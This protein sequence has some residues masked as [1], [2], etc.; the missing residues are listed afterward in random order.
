MKPT[1][2]DRKNRAYGVRPKCQLCGAR[3]FDW[4]SCPYDGGMRHPRRPRRPL[5]PAGNSP[6]RELQ[7]D[8]VS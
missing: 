2:I 7:E 5:P 6:R 1:Q 8:E 3:H 4:E